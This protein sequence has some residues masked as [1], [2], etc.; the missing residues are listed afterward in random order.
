MD[1]E[2]RWTLLERVFHGALA[3]EPVERADYIRTECGDNE[4]LR[5]RVESLLG[6]DSGI[7]GKNGPADFPGLS[8][9]PYR[10]VSRLGAGG[11]G[12]VYLAFDSRLN[13]HVAIKVLPPRLVSDPE[14]KRRFLHEARAAS[15]LN[16]PNIVT[17]FDVGTD[18]ELDYIVM[19]YVPGRPLDRLIPHNGL[20]LKEALAYSVQ[21]VDALACAHAAGIIHRDLKPANIA[22][23]EAGVAKVLDFGLAKLMGGPALSTET[24]AGTILGTLAYMS[25]EQAAGAPVDARSDI[26]SFG[27]M[28]YE[29]TT[30]RRPFQRDS[31]AATLAAIVNDEPPR[32]DPVADD[33]PRSIAGII[34]R[35]MRKDSGQ[36]FAS[37]MDLKTALTA[38]PRRLAA[39]R[40][41]P[42]V[43][44]GAAASLV[45]LAAALLLLLMWRDRWERPQTS[46]VMT[47]T[48]LT[49][50]P[51]DESS[52]TFSPDG[53]QVA[54]VWSGPKGDNE[55]IYIKLIG[56]HEAVR[57]TRNPLPDAAPAW[58]PDGKWIAFLR[59]GAIA[60]YRQS[61]L[62]VIPA[63]GGPE[64]RIA[65]IT[66]AGV[67][68]PQISWDASSRFLAVPDK[69]SASEAEALYLVS[70]QDGG[71]RR[72][73]S[74]NA[75][76]IGDEDPSFSPDGRSIAFTRWGRT[77][78]AADIYV[79][80]LA[81]DFTPEGE[82]LRL[83]TS[84]MHSESPTWSVDG[85]SV[86]YASGSK[87][88]PRLW[89]AWLPE[90]G[91]RSRPAEMLSFAGQGS[92]TPEISRTGRLAFS[93]FPTNSNIKRLELGGTPTNP[94]AL[95]V[96]ETVAPSTRLNHT[97]Q[98][99]PDGSRIA[100]AS[101]R[102]GNHEI[103]ACDRD[104]SNALPLTSFGGPYTADP[105]WSPDGRLIAF[106]SNPQGRDAVF[107]IGASGGAP[108][109][110]TGA[111]I[112]AGLC[113]WSRDGKWVYYSTGPLSENRVWKISRDGG[114]P[115]PVSDRLGRGMRFIESADG[116]AVFY[117]VADDTDAAS[118][119]RMP[120]PSG[121]PEKVLG[122]VYC[123]NFAVT[124]TGIFFIASETEPSID[125]LRFA[126]HK[127][128]TVVR[129]GRE[130]PVC[131]MSIAP[132]GR[133]LLFGQFLKYPA[134]LMLVENYR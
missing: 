104:G 128:M 76:S 122:S 15:A 112:D 25:P 113:G 18:R 103:W 101:D 12:E 8:I 67:W 44:M 4:D 88:N 54:F 66:S 74:S 133:S 120:L 78:K 119:W 131:G 57:L 38:V 71:K 31:A 23:T 93:Y 10:V 117:E 75:D 21:I 124:D 109:R 9:G 90:S 33:V 68:L 110:L 81:A 59:H 95:G 41:K 37:A 89:R 19:E 43:A 5:R 49:T 11:M 105:L 20:K 106:N 70:V 60:R 47:A 45:A 62:F 16:H 69:S 125:F 39:V 35:C 100:F 46:Q 108:K 7:D 6:H 72:L 14:R 28:L 96:P 53:N 58:S 111:D 65:E 56:E 22:V 83:S 51:F 134:D 61:V 42:W 130:M 30:G 52:P 121:K 97:P 126:D 29:M 77:Y 98:Y 50:Y 99:S 114:A 26:F 82:P 102:S 127:T 85:R 3:L 2:A 132:D 129:L 92:R 48:E 36:R 1:D 86:V 55:D 87:H 34:E 13:R 91:I 40:R 32:I 118:L 64:R 73:T 24:A 80:R 94:R 123:L 79:L 115:A 116:R 84:G 17:I 63:T 107:V 27:S